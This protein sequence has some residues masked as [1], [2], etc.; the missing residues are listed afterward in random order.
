MEYIKAAL[1]MV[2]F[3][4]KLHS[5]RIQTFISTV[6]LNSA[7][8]ELDFGTKWLLSAEHIWLHLCTDLLTYTE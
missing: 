6:L 7:S 5:E 8:G 2:L 4:F 3:I 1:L